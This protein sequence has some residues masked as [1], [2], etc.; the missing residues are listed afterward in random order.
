M[1]ERADRVRRIGRI[2]GIVVLAAIALACFVGLVTREPLW[3]RWAPDK[4]PP[5]PNHS[6][7]R[8]HATPGPRCPVGAVS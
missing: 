6:R 5:V 2:I 3:R 1:T 4:E 7:F 8:P